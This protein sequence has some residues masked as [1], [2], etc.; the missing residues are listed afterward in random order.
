ML[1]HPILFLSITVLREIV[2]AARQVFEVHRVLF[3][4]LYFISQGSRVNSPLL[5]IFLSLF[6]LVLNLSLMKIFLKAC[7]TNTS[8]A[9]EPIESAAF[10]PF[11]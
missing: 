4:S 3:T 2:H 11:F 7:T 10:V 1:K 5:N 6:F 8:E 9:N